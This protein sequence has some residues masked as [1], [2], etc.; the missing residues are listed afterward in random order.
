VGLDRKAREGIL[1]VKEEIHKRTS[2]SNAGFRQKMRIEVDM[3]DYATKRVL[4][5]E[6]EDGQWKPV[7]YLL[8]SLNKTER[9][10][11]IYNK[12]MLAVIRDLEN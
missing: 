1:G 12:K 4:P 6:Y 10:Y 7:A 8:K 11:N 2:V 5:I 3:S 9:N